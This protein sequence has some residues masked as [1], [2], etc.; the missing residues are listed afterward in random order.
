[1]LT[2][3]PTLLF[4]LRIQQ[5]VEKVIKNDDDIVSPSEFLHQ[6]RQVMCEKKKSMQVK[7]RKLTLTSE[8]KFEKDFESGNCQEYGTALDANIDS[9]DQSNSFL[10]FDSNLSMDSEELNTFKSVFMPENED[11]PE[12]PSKAEDLIFPNISFIEDYFE[13]ESIVGEGNNNEVSKN[14][15]TKALENMQ[16]LLVFGHLLYQS[17]TYL[18]SEKI[19]DMKLYQDMMEV[20]SLMILKDIEN[21]S[22]AHLLDPERRDILAIDLNASIL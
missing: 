8:K 9:L 1:M 18:L 13:N 6:I 11:E 4:S 15:E 21:S 2:K 14:I 5:Y 20:F 19:I 10:N 12:L 3:N 16:C 7:N 17:G 22:M